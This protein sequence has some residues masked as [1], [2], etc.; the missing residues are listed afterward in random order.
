MKGFIENEKR[1]SLPILFDADQKVEKAYGV[2]GV[3]DA[4]FLDREGKVK[5]RKGGYDAKKEKETLDEY[6]KIIQEML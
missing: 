3:P 1:I 6:K 2:R 5:S 4:F